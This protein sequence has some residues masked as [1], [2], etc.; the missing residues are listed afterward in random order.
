MIVV[1][2]FRRQRRNIP[3]A[4]FTARSPLGKKV[5]KLSKTKIWVRT[6]TKDA[7]GKLKREWLVFNLGKNEMHCADCQR[8]WPPSE[9]E[10]FLVETST[11]KLESVH[12]HKI[13]PKY[14][15]SESCA[16]NETVAQQ[17]PAATTAAVTLAALTEAQQDCVSKL[18]WTAHY[19]SFALGKWKFA[20]ASGL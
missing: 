12:F 4:I 5:D 1:F 9:R 16:N 14:Q 8:Y 6:L 18:M 19:K 15:S 2:S 11:F 20:W 13:S 7:K 17:R 10:P 3:I